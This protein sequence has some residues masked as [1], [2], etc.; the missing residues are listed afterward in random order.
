MQYLPSLIM[1]TSTPPKTTK[2]IN[3]L[4]S[5]LRS[6]SSSHPGGR[7]IG[8]EVLPPTDLARW[9]SKAS[10]NDSGP[11]VFFCSQR[12]FNISQHPLGNK[13]VTQSSQTPLKNKNW[14]SKDSWELTYSQ[15]TPK[16]TRRVQSVLDFLASIIRGKWW[17]LTKIF[18][19]GWFSHQ[20]E[21]YFG[22]ILSIPDK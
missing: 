7:G 12:I 8:E 3:G 17:K 10:W 5:R 18:Q 14:R 11:W 19:T 22:I 21:V 15:P 4:S 13:C 1:E 6:P 16:F 20:V 9:K 2:G